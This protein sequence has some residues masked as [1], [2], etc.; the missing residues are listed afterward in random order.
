MYIEL[1]LNIY[2]ALNAALFDSVDVFNEDF[3]WD[4]Y[5]G[6]YYTRRNISALESAMITTLITLKMTYL[7]LKDTENYQKIDKILVK[8][9]GP[10][11]KQELEDLISRI[12]K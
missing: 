11:D 12:R 5:A 8:F 3:D 1:F 4:G 7:E 10:M 9:S 6:A 2:I